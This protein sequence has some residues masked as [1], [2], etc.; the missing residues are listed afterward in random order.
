[1]ESLFCRFGLSNRF[2]HEF[3]QGLAAKVRNV[4]RNVRNVKYYKRKTIPRYTNPIPNVRPITILYNNE[5]YK[6]SAF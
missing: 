5:P 4:L 3:P 2:D 6:I 1:M